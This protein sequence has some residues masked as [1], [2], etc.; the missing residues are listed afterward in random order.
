MLVLLSKILEVV[1]YPLGLIFVLL[2]LTLLLQKSRRWQNITIALALG[3][4]FLSG[5]RVVAVFLTYSLEWQY[6]PIIDVPQT[7]VI[8]VLTGDSESPQFP[9][10]GVELDSTGDRALYAARLYKQGKAPYLLISGGNLDN[11]DVSASSAAQDTANVL[12][13][14]GVPKS[15]IWLE[16]KSQNT[17]ESAVNCREI[18]SQKGID[19]ITLVTS[20]MH[21]PRAVGVF[22]KQGFDVFAAPTD[23]HVTNQPLRDITQG[24][25]LTHVLDLFPGLTNLSLTTSALKE[26]FGMWAYRLMGWM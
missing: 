15:A 16:Y 25:W 26:Y 6:Y 24:Y 22:K 12:T 1:L 14:M 4:L 5:N 13:L 21:M 3:L 19:R 17:Y 23:F 7:R 2:I 9:R 10:P 20:A 18:L 8:V 11:P